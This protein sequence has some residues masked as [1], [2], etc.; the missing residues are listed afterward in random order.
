MKFRGRLCIVTFP[1]LN[2]FPDS[3]REQEV[4]PV[5]FTESNSLQILYK[6]I[7]IHRWVDEVTGQERL[8]KQMQLIQESAKLAFRAGSDVRRGWHELRKGRVPLCH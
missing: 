3:R 5:L 7:E 1:T 4:R 8:E 6:S 2:S